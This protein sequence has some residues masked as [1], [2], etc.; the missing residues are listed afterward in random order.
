M[1]PECFVSDCAQ[2][3]K[4]G[5]LAEDDDDE[6]LDEDSLLETPL[7]KVEPYGLFKDSLL[8]E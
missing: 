3:Q 4:F 8:S 6:E 7:D 5:Q 2:A 1:L